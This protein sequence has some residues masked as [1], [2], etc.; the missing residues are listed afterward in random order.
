MTPDTML[1][2]LIRQTSTTTYCGQ[3]D[4]NGFT[5]E[6]LLLCDASM[7]DAK[8][9]ASIPLKALHGPLCGFQCNFNALNSFLNAHLVPDEVTPYMRPYISSL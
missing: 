3:L 5:V 7:C 4:K 1:T 9:C 2:S 8:D 6:I